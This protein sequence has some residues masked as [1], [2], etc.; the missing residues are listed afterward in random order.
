[1]APDTVTFGILLALAAKLP[2]AHHIILLEKVKD[3]AARLWYMQA[4]VENG[5]SRA[6]LAV[7]IEQHAHR[8][9]G[10]AVTWKGREIRA[11]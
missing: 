10:K 11:D 2:W 4:A 5:W 8:R 7:Q 9:A 3:R 1:M 6:V